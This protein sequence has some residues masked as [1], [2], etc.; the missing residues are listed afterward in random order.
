MVKVR[1]SFPPLV[2]LVC[3]V[4]AQVAGKPNFMAIAW[5]TFIESRSMKVGVVSEKVHHTN[6]GIHEHNCFSINIPSAGMVEKTDYCGIH[7]GNRVDKSAVFEVFYGELKEAP[8]ISECPVTM[9]CRLVRTVEFE[10]NEMLVGE[11]VGVYVENSCLTG[12]KGDVLK[13]DPLLY[14]GGK[15]AMY[16]KIGRQI[17]KAYDV[18]KGFKPKG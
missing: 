17:A 9:E 18:G 2:S 16:W 3:L 8:M 10:H 15:P 6:K 4:G 11:V 7:S 12:D 14:E 5:W 1:L 13:V